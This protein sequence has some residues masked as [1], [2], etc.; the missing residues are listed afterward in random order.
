MLLW[1]AVDT[2]QTI[3][4]NIVR[5]LVEYSRRE[6]GGIGQQGEGSRAKIIQSLDVTS[7]KKH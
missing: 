5:V 2:S 7:N 6:L 1:A 4:Y 3:T